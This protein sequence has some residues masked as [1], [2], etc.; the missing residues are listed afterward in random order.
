MFSSLSLIKKTIR[1]LIRLFC[2]HEVPTRGNN[3]VLRLPFR[4]LSSGMKSSVKNSWFTG[5]LIRESFR[6]RI[7]QGVGW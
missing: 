3:L 2:F 4:L 1:S 7:D 6:K 5:D